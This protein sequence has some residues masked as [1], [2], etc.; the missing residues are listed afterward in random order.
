MC[1]HIFHY[2]ILVFGRVKG[3]GAVVIVAVILA[4]VLLVVAVA[5]ARWR[6]VPLYATGHRRVPT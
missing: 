6:C 3:E 4:V 1:A 2:V 5:G